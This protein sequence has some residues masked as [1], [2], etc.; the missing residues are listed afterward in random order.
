MAFPIDRPYPV[1]ANP[2]TVRAAA[3]LPAAGNWDAAPV[4]LAVIGFRWVL[5]FFAYTRGAAGGAFDFQMQMSP[6]PA[7]VGGVES[8][9][10]QS[11]YA[12][13][14]VAAGVD[15]QGRIQREYIT[16]ASTAAGAEDFVY[17]PF[18]INSVVERFRLRARESGV[19]GT[20]GTL[21]VVG[22]AYL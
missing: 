16:Y 9:F 21:H 11:I 8:W 15:T 5:L 10:M 3:A 14:A 22:V 18:E 17:G 19:V 6:Y 1:L 12:A 13:G 2:I 4:E 20:P 7:D